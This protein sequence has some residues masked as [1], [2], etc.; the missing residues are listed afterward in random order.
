MDCVAKQMF[1]FIFYNSSPTCRGRRILAIYYVKH[2]HTSHDCQQVSFI[3]FCQSRITL[4]SVPSFY[5]CPGDCICNFSHL[6]IT[7][8]LYLWPH[9]LFFSF[10]DYLLLYT[11]DRICNFSHLQIIPALYLWPHSHFF[12]FA[13][14]LPLRTSDCIHNY[15]HLYIISALYLW[16]HSQF[17]SFADYLL[18]HTSPTTVSGDAYR[19]DYPPRRLVFPLHFVKIKTTQTT[20]LSPK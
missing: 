7:P 20:M 19:Q 4:P 17:F 11:C 15:S 12:P 5:S 13:D 14:Y 1:F 6:Q 9:F 10:V 2:T 8:A 18:R 3:C 16:P